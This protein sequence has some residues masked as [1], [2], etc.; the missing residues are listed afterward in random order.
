MFPLRWNFPFRKKDGSVTTIDDAI[1]SGGGGGGGYTLPTAS[2]STKGGVKIGAGLTMEGEVLNNT[3]PTPYSLPTASAE[4]LGGVKVGSGLSITDGVLSAT[5]GGGGSALYSHDIVFAN[6]RDMVCTCH[7]ISD[8]GTAFT[9]SSLATYLASKGYDGNTSNKYVSA[10]GY[11]NS[12]TIYGIGSS[13][14]TN[15]QTFNATN[16]SSAFPSSVTVYDTVIE[17]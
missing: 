9:L 6:V 2:A 3:N 13:D 17:L 16:A 7:I 5:G 8:S 12:K 10:Y 4:T 14:G 11:Y 1:S 15:V